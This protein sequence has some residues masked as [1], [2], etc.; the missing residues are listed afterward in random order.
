MAQPKT[1]GP[2]VIVS[3]EFFVS[4]WCHG[5]WHKAYGPYTT[6]KTARDVAKQAGTF[7]GAPRKLKVFQRRT[8]VEEKPI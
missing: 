7:N 3:T 6:V 2:L 5:R 8:T 1:G 4:E